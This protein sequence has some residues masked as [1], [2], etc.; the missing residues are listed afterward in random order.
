MIVS[1]RELC[2]RNEPRRDASRH[3]PRRVLSPGVHHEQRPAVAHRHS[4]ADIHC[5]ALHDARRAGRNGRAR[6][7]QIR[8][9]DAQG[10]RDHRVIGGLVRRHRLS[11]IFLSGPI[12]WTLT[13]TCSIGN[14]TADLL[15]MAAWESVRNAAPNEDLAPISVRL[16]F[17]YLPHDRRG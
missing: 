15:M 9:E 4:H 6:C 11:S 13:L 3:H 7:A 1:R 14:A 2:T 10:G 16:P 8:W 5:A 17:N 12:Y